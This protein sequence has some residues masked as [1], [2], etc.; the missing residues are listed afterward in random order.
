MVRLTDEER[1]F[2]KIGAGVP[3]G[4]FWHFPAILIALILAGSTVPD[5][6]LNCTGNPIDGGR[7]AGAAIR[8]ALTYPCSPYLLREGLWGWLLFAGLWLPIPFALINLFWQRRHRAF[9]DRVRARERERR[10]Q[11]REEQRKSKAM[12]KTGA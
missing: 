1:S 2:R 12:N 11:R 10:R 9:W 3:F 5:L 4:R 8:M 6:Y 7:K